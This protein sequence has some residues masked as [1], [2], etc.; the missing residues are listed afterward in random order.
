MNDGKREL[1]ELLIYLN[2]QWRKSE[3]GKTVNRSIIRVTTPSREG[4]EFLN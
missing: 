2:G 1:R 3:I 4:M